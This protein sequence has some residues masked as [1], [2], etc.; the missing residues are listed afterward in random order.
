MSTPLSLFVLSPHSYATTRGSTPRRASSTSRM[1]CAPARRSRRTA[2]L[3]QSSR[4]RC[5]PC[6]AP[7]SSRSVTRREPCKLVR[8]TGTTS[9]YDEPDDLA[10]G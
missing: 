9:W 7:S 8:R 3:P 1:S 6:R 2:R 10:L 5:A 4:R